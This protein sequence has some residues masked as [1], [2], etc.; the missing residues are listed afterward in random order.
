MP[1][2]NAIRT[3]R[4]IDRTLDGYL[5]R[6]ASYLVPLG[7]SAA[8]TGGK[9]LFLPHLKDVTPDLAVLAGAIGIPA[10]FHLA[11]KYPGGVP[12]LLTKNLH[13]TEL[14]RSPLS[15]SMMMG[16]ISTLGKQAITKDLL[17]TLQKTRANNLIDQARAAYQEGVLPDM[18]KGLKNVYQS[19]KDRYFSALQELAAHRGEPLHNSHKELLDAFSTPEEEATRAAIKL[20]LGLKANSKVPWKLQDEFPPTRYS[21]ALAQQTPSQMA[22]SDVVDT[23]FRATIPRRGKKLMSDRDMDIGIVQH[24]AGEHGDRTNS[25]R[26]DDL[27]AYLTKGSALQKSAIDELLAGGAAAAGMGALAVGEHVGGNMYLRGVLN[28]PSKRTPLFRDALLGKSNT[29]FFKGFAQGAF[30]PELSGIENHLA[31]YGKNIRELSGGFPKL[32]AN[33]PLRVPNNV[34]GLVNRFSK[35]L[36]RDKNPLIRMLPDVFDEATVKELTSEKS[37]LGNGMSLSGKIGTTLGAASR[38]LPIPGYG[39]PIAGTINSV[40]SMI[41]LNKKLPEMFTNRVV[42]P[43]ASHF[44]NQGLKG[45]ALSPARK[46]FL[47]TVVSP[48]TGNIADISNRFGGSGNRLAKLMQRVKI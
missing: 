25:Q 21:Q 7:V 27:I 28:N 18:S 45:E 41:G 43:V 42:K 47:D 15:P 32:N 30:L 12:Y 29:G 2:A 1:I 34:G 35:S 3:Q 48:I 5:G 40:K 38:F 31:T 10:A 20:S 9:A 33:S 22:P 8:Y 11:S 19:D 37:P 44:Y 17:L 24:L 4:A 46:T 36:A 13:G 39:N 23:L 14:Q 26:V 6:I 16:K